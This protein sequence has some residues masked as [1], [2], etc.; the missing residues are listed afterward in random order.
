MG[1]K[2]NPIPGRGKRNICCPY[3]GDCLDSAIDRPFLAVL[4]LL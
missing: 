3:Y 4:E 2:A 1:E